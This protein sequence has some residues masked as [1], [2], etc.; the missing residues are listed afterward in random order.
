MQALINKIN[1]SILAPLPTMYTVALWVLYALSQLSIVTY[2]DYLWYFKLLQAT[3]FSCQSSNVWHT[4]CWIF[5]CLFQ[6]GTY[7]KHATEKSRAETE[8]MFMLPFSSW[9]CFIL[10]NITW[11]PPYMQ[12]NWTTNRTHSIPWKEVRPSRKVCYCLLM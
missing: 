1:K 5:C 7:Q 6:S 3:H 8:C 2:Q 4:V 10:L 11:V 9:L 12:W